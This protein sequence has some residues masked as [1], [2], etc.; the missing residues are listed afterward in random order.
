MTFKLTDLGKLLEAQ[1]AAGSKPIITRI[2]GSDA[3]SSNPEALLAVQDVKQT[4][5]V[6]AVTVVDGKSHLKFILSNIGLNEEYY[7]KQIG[8]YAKQTEDSEEI[9]YFIGQDRNG[10]RIP[11]IS[12]KEVEFEYDLTITVDNAYEVTVA[13]SGNDFARK[14]MLDK[15][16]DGNGGDISETVIAATEESQA[17]YPVPAAGDSAKTVLGKVQKFFADIRNWMTGV[18]LLGQIVNNCVTDNAKLP[19]S[20]A[21]GKQL[22]DAITVLNT[23]QKSHFSNGIMWTQNNSKTYTAALHSGT[24]GFSYWDNVNESDKTVSRLQFSGNGI[25]EIVKLLNDSTTVKRIFTISPYDIEQVQFGHS[26]GNNLYIR[27]IVTSNL[28]YQLVCTE[29]KEIRFDK[30]DGTSWKNLWVK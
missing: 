4:L 12:E 5:Q 7:L 24:D 2:E 11:A 18:C 8:I 22:Q 30:Y 1:L 25:L 17:E 14:E 20:A 13:V 3:Y 29:N 28:Q 16:I 27:W 6:E 9:L 23:N 15:K 10:E 21:M 19:L 26:A